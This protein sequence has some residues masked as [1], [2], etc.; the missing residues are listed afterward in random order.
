MVTQTQQTDELTLWQRW[1]DKHDKKALSELMKSYMPVINDVVN[2]MGNVTL[3]PTVMKAQAKALV[4]NAFNTYN[5]KQSQL[6]THVFNQLQPLNRFVAKYTNIGFIPE[7]RFFLISQYSRMKSE[8]EDKLNREPTLEELSEHLKWPMEMV[9]KIDKESRGAQPAGTNY[10]IGS[11]DISDPA[12]LAFKS[13]YYTL[14][15]KEKLVI[16]YL[17]GYGK[18]KL[19]VSEIKKKTGMSESEINKIKEKVKKQIIE[20]NKINAT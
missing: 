14:N 13:V 9:A 12:L 8:L 1:H 7:N 17:L 18:P 10:S 5:P 15:P 16:E 2:K 6:N 3:S 20:W 11:L 19:T 4:Y